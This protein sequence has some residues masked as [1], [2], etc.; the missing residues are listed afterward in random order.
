M[1]KLLILGAGTA[2]TIMANKLAGVLSRDEWQITI[3]DRDESHHYQPGYLFIPFGIY[4]PRDVVKP[5]RDYL[6]RGVEV[7][8]GGIEVIEPDQN[9]VRLSGGRVLGYD[10][11]IIA[12]GARPVPAQTEGLLGEEWHRSIFDF[13]T[14]EGASALARRLQHW[15]GGRLVINIV[16]MPIKCPVA[17]L[18][19]AFLAD[20]FFTEAGLRPKVEIEYVT[21][22]P[23]AF[24]KPRAAAMLGDFLDKKNIRLTAEFA[25]GS[26]DA[27]ARKIVSWDQREVAYD[28][29]VTIPTNMGDEA[30]ARSGFG[31][32]LNFIPTDKHT[33]RS[34]VKD[35][36]FVLGDATDLP[37][38]K[39]G[40]VAHFQA[41]ILFE[42]LLDAIDGRPLRAHFD[43]HANCFIESGFNKGLLI[44]FN[45]ETE[46]LP[47]KFPLPGI[48]PFSLLEE[49]KM[50]HY[51]KM[52]FRWV[53]WNLLLRGAELPIEAEM[54]MAGKR[55]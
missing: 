15:E 23:G 25:T 5:R 55:R 50:N 2:G 9:R 31:D 33:L 7:V 6:P 19:F 44:D 45:Y 43:G 46:P 51:G 38:S 3:V 13:Y 21:P 16:E 49:T 24:T 28:L 32:E 1:K 47:G 8:M 54:T 37:A 17:P 36:I 30:I 53:Y 41:D 11:L 18:E 4:T 26:V 14:L 35:N 52:M 12:T 40:S 29:L 20:W 34:K 42:N 10:F 39:A 48:G 22:L 27:G